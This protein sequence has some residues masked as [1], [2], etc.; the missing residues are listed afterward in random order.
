MQ[1]NAAPCLGPSPPST[2]H[3]QGPRTPRKLLV[4]SIRRTPADIVAQTFVAGAATMPV[5]ERAAC[6]PLELVWVRGTSETGL[7]IVGGP[8]ASQLASLVPG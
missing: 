7:G 3:V 6:S 2:H 4:L 8:L 5:I 1:S